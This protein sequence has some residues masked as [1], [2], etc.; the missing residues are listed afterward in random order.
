M[1]QAAYDQSLR[2]WE[3]G[4]GYPKNMARGSGLL[5]GTYNTDPTRTPIE[6]IFSDTERW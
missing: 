3:R 2:R 5:P 4:L 6:R 1:Y